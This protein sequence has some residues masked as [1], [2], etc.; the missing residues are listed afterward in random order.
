MPRR[1][2]ARAGSRRAASALAR[3]QR[4]FQRGELRNLFGPLERP[5]ARDH[6]LERQDAKTQSIHFSLD[7]SLV[8]GAEG[9]E[10]VHREHD[11]EPLEPLSAE[12][13][14]FQP[15]AQPPYR[16]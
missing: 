15:E 5:L 3:Q 4:R 8:L 14:R 13:R 9:F 1:R 11:V 10:S 16:R 12:G 2:P 6:P 7:A